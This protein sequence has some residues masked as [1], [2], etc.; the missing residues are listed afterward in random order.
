MEN[1]RLKYIEYLPES[2]IVNNIFILLHGYGSNNNDLLEL[3][4]NFIDLLPNTA[5]ISVNASTECE[6]GIGYQWF[7]L[8]TM[9][10]FSILKE[11]KISNNLLNNFIDKQLKRFNLT[12][13]NLLIGGFSQGAMMT[14]YTGLRR[15]EAPLGLLSF[16]GMM[17][18]TVDSLRKEIKCRPDTLLIHGTDD[19]VVPYA[20]LERSENI[21]REFDVP[22]E[23][24][25]IQYMQ[26]MINP[27][28]IVYAREF[29]KNICNGF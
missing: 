29:I 28:C 12:D 2:N 6:S 15:N 23:A 5:F 7:S 1:N 17:A 26:H 25:S 4:M 14:M 22:Y 8:K 24:H 16:S 19:V 18:D 11:I 3:G 20:N 10:L 9:N 27:E 13:E 21:L